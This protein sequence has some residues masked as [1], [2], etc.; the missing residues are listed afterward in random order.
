MSALDL[1][2]AVDRGGFR[3][4]VAGRFALDGITGV[5]GASG[6]GKTTLLRALAG[7]EPAARG[8][9]ALGDA[10]WQDDARRV[11]MPA[12]RRRAG[13]VFQDARLFGHLGVAGNLRYA[14]R[15]APRGAAGP[16][17]D[18]VVAM[19]DLAPLLSRDT[20]SL[21]GGERQR[22]AIGRALLA[23]PRL[24]LMD[25]PLAALDRPRRAA[26]LPL[27]E[28]VA[29]ETRVPIL[30]VTHSLDEL[31]RLAGTVVVLEDGRVA[32]SGPLARVL[33]HPAMRRLAGRFE[34]GTLLEGTVVAHDA[35][36]AMTEVALAGGHR[37]RMPAVDLPP[38]APVRLRIRARDVALAR[39]APEAISIRNTFAGTVAAIVEEDGAFAEVTVDLGG[40]A[41]LG[42][43]V[44]RESVAA[45][46]L[47]AGGPV[48]ALVKSVALDR[49]MLSRG[50][51][52][53][54]GT[55]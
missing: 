1:D 46:G 38:G 3:L 21:S 31:A 10:V 5:F 18:E 35:H 36:W 25:E 34:A 50:E 2:I 27:I 49:R 8:R 30:W 15:R 24:L 33:E 55:G 41:H 20:A 53:T 48:V 42:A 7:L 39:T 23:A 28:R 45:L 11:R 13:L 29:A 43:R 19:L 26:I 17:F 16:S 40:G 14:A 47:A 54:D 6:H 9:I 22:V 12:W 44:T 4:A 32:A 37:L 52:V 51:A